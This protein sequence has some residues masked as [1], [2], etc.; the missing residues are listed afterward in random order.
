MK[1]FLRLILVAMKLAIAIPLM[2]PNQP[3]IY[4]GF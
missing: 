1:I 4:Q 3:F 2:T